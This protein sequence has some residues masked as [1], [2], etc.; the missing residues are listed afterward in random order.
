MKTMM[1]CDKCKKKISK[2]SVD[3]SKHFH[4]HVTQIAR[5][6]AQARDKVY[7]LVL[8]KAIEIECDGGE[9]YPYTIVPRVVQSPITGDVFTHDLPEPYRTS[10]CTNK[11]MMTAVEA[12][13]QYAVIDCYPAIILNEK[14][15]WYDG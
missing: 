10:T 12:A 3:I 2:R 6:T 7:F 9:A 8:L 13:H 14:G 11:Q 1:I 4:S 15:K 5:E